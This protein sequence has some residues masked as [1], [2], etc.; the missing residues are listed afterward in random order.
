M[1][2]SGVSAESTWFC[3]N[4]TCP[5][6]TSQLCLALFLL[7][8]FRRV[9]DRRPLVGK[10]LPRL[11]LRRSF[12]GPGESIQWETHSFL[13]LQWSYKVTVYASPFHWTITPRWTY[14]LAALYIG[15]SQTLFP[16]WFSHVSSRLPS[17]S[18][19]Q[20]VFLIFIKE[21]LFS[22]ER[23]ILTAPQTKTLR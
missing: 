1:S 14:S 13:T 18:I 16:F 2:A 10:L 19:W 4:S 7:L 11:L 8:Q 5:A 6:L 22:P 3:G 15:S 17:K 23:S 20:F 9:R 12:S 21:S